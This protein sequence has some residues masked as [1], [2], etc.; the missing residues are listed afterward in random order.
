MKALSSSLYSKSVTIFI[1]GFLFVSLLTPFTVFAQT[2]SNNQDLASILSSIQKILDDISKAVVMLFKQQSQ[3]QVPTSGLVGHW[4]FDE[5]AGTTAADSSGSNNTGTLVNGPVWT[6]SG[7]I[8]GGL[9]FDGV[10]D[11]VDVGNPSAIKTLA[12][13]TVSAWIRPQSTAR[14]DYITQWGVGGTRHFNLISGITAGKFDFFV[15]INGTASPSAGASITSINPGTWYHVVGTYDGANIRLYVN[16]VQESITAQTG[17]LLTT[18]SANLLFGKGS[19]ATSGIITGSIDDVRVYN[20]ALSAADIAELYNYTGAPPSSDTTAPSVPTGLVA[21]VVSSSQINL[22]WSASTDNVGVT[23][24]R[25]YRGGI[26][27]ASVTT[28]SYSD[29]ALTAATTYSYTVA[30]YDA[31]GNVS[32]Q[33]SAVSTTT[34]AT[35]PPPPPPPSDTTPPAVSITAPAGGST[36]SGTVTV[37]ASASDNVGVAGVQFKLDGVNLQSEDT[38]SP[39]SISWDTTSA[40]NA[41]HTLTATAR[42]AAGNQTTA[43]VI[44]VTV[45][46]AAPPSSTL[47]YLRAGATGNGSGSDWTNACT[48]FTGS[49]AVA[50]LVRGHTY[51]VANGTYA[52]RIFN[53][54]ES[55]S[56]VITIKG[57]TAADHGTATRWSNS[58][59]VSA[60]DGGAQARWRTDTNVAISIQTG[61]WVID[62]SVGSGNTLASYGF[63]IDKPTNCNTQPTAGIDIGNGGTLSTVTVMHFSADACSQG[64]AGS[65]LEFNTAQR[66]FGI[67]C[68]ACLNDNILIAHNYGKNWGVSVSMTNTRNSTF[69]YNWFEK[70]HYS[71]S[72]S[73]KEPYAI[74]CNTGSPYGSAVGKCDNVTIRYSVIRDCM[75]SGMT[76]ALAVLGS[77]TSQVDGMNSWNIYGNL[78]ANCSP[79][80][81]T[82][83]GANYGSVR[84]TKIYNNTFVNVRNFFRQCEADCTLAGNNVIENNLLY[85]SD[86]RYLGA[87]G[88]ITRD[89]NAYFSAVDTPPTETN[90]QIASGNPFVNSAGGDYHL[91][92]GT[93][94]GLVLVSPFNIDIAGLIR[95]ADGIWDRGAYEFVSSSPPPPPADTIAP[96][97][98]TGLTATAVSSSQ[99]NLSWTASTDNVGVAGYRVYRGGTQI[100]SV[101]TGTSYQNTGLSPATTYSYT[102]AAYDAAGNVSAQSTSVSA[103]TLAPPDTIPPVISSVLANSL[104]TSGAT[105]TWITNEGATS[106]VEY[107]LTTT[108]GSLSSLDSNLLLSH[109]VI[110]SGLA[111]NTT[112]NYRVR[113]LDGAGNEAIST[114]QTFTTLVLPDTTPPAEVITLSVTLPTQTSLTLSWT[115]VGDDNNTGTASSYEIRRSTSTPTDT[116]SW[117][118]NAA[119]LTGISTPAVAGTPQTYTAV[120]LSPSTTYYFAVRARDDVSLESP[121]SLSSIKSGMTAASPP[122][123]TPPV[124]SSINVANITYATA[125]ITWTTDENANSRVEYGLTTSYGFSTTLKTPLITT[126]LTSLSNLSPNTLYHYRAVSV[127]SS[128]NQAFSSDRTFSTVPLPDINAPIISAVTVTNIMANSATIT[129]S[130]NENS[131][132]QIE[133]GLIDTLGFST[134]ETDTVIPVVGHNITLTNLISCS[135]YHYRV[136]SAD[137]VGNLTVGAKGIFATIGCPGNT[138]ILDETTQL[139]NLTGGS[140]ILPVNSRN[141]LTLDI[142]ADFNSTANYFQAKRVEKDELLSVL[143]LPASLKSALT[144]YYFLNSFTSPTTTLSSFAKPVNITLSY[145]DEEIVGIDV[146][147]LA[148]YRHNGTLWQKL[149]NCTINSSAKKITCTTTNF[150]SFMLAGSP[151]PEPTSSG[152]G[153]GGGGGISPLSSDNIPPPGVRKLSIVEADTQAFLSWEN[154]A[155]SLD[156]VRTIVVRKKGSLPRNALDGESIYEGVGT[157][158]VDIKFDKFS[159]YQYAVFTFD[160]V[161]NYSKGVTIITSTTP[162]V[163]T[164]SLPGITPF[165][166]AF[167]PGGSRIFFTRSLYLGTRGDDVTNLQKILA[168]DKSLYPKGIVTGFYGSLT[169]AAVGR[170]QVKYNIAKQGDKGYGNFGPKTREKM[171]EIQ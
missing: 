155:E 24:Y 6:P 22:S 73:G 54:P 42:D 147:T 101:T 154:P 30:A 66:F 10:D 111:P 158:T 150:S 3:A 84:N 162:P 168:S 13:I 137:V 152:G 86:S 161:P 165:S 109:S 143:T 148:I 82:I 69:E 14:Q 1:S 78:F 65:G 116:A 8:N 118:N 139:V 26:Q 107:G 164:P 68:G 27:I 163:A 25:V 49:C 103:T 45:S 124:I 55:G 133:Y 138:L 156:W 35:P 100:A 79:N 122:D 41:S 167:V 59:S 160:R 12:N 18:S 2:P 57:A 70:H 40:S 129:W 140:L 136:L 7:K 153:G 166:P 34:Q 135:Q 47:H 56:L 85:S 53:T 29:T 97:V 87:G 144:H 4:M 104:T 63:T 28:T 106:Q 37:S 9:S 77:G 62:G 23:G 134:P 60:G 99:I 58:Y 5:G 130:T 91:A 113:S 38:A 88:T 131:D 125:D 72:N 170:F 112:Y 123:I 17:D 141:A 20:R 108:Y 48:D 171:N 19:D 110:L 146:P 11:F 95:G 145:T 15:S 61:F 71:G 74:A 31:A 67:G 115:A 119:V 142:P 44:T 64:T 126:H 117:W 92:A 149:P 93:L 39:Y 80:T 96:S 33:S 89:Y 98:P 50:S 114:N 46:N 132:S 43:A 102:V 76:G 21:T 52:S 32:A 83:G 120:G 90:G 105:I 121:L 81:A 157:S 75:E 151:A 159:D 51:Y 169:R 36:V 128:G 127:D 94:A 16:G